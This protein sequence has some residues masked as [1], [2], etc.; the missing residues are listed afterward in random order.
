VNL[1][2]FIIAG[3]V[4]GSVY[5]LAAV[6]LVL[7]YKTSGIFNF[8]YGALATVAAYAFYSLYVQ[9]GV[10]L[11]V[12]LLISSVVLGVALGFA[13]EPFARRLGHTALALQV[14]AT[15]GIVLIVESSA[16]IIYGPDTLTFPQWLPVNTVLIF[17]AHVEIGQLIIFAVS[18]VATALLYS[19]LRLTR[20]GK[21]LRAVVDND[22]LIDLVG[23][24][25]R[26]LR[27]I[28]WIVGCFFAALSGLLLAPTLQLNPSV[29]TLLVIQAFGAAALGKFTSLPIAWVGGLAIGVGASLI[30]EFVPTT[31]AV[32]GGLAA[33]LPFIVLFGASFFFREGFSL[34]RFRTRPQGQQE[35]APVAGGRKR[36][37]PRLAII[38]VVAVFFLAIPTFAGARISSWSLAVT[39]IILFLSL[40]LLV[41]GSGLVSLCAV[42]FAAIGAAAFSQIGMHL[43]FPW[44]PTLLLA[45][46][47]A[48]PIGAIL[49]VPAMRIGG[50]F[51]ALATLG[52][53]LLVQSMFYE[54]S[55]MFGSN[56]GGI[57]VPMPSI[58]ILGISGTKAFYYVVLL[59]AVVTMLFMFWI[60]RGR[61]GH[62]MR[63]I[64][65]QPVTLVASGARVEVTHVLIFCISAY[66][67][68]V[69]G[70]LNAMT[71][72]FVNGLSFDPTMSLTLLTLVVITV[73]SE[74]WYAI[75][76]G[77]GIALIPAYVNSTDTAYYLQLIFGLSAVGMAVFHGKLR[78]PAVLTRLL[79][80]RSGSAVAVSQIEQGQGVPPLAEY[81]QPE[82]AGGE[83][84]R[85]VTLSGE[86]LRL[87]DVS[88]RFGGLVALD[89]VS[90]AVD[91]G[92]IIGLV[93]ANGAG[94]STLIN[95]CSGFVR[96]SSGHVVFGDHDVTRSDASARAR[97]GLGRTFQH[98]QLCDSLT[99]ADNV[100]IG[101]EA[102]NAGRYPWAH[103]FASPSKR[104]AEQTAT[105]D[106]LE[107]CGLVGKADVLAGHL[108][109]GERRLVEV[110]RS[111]AAGFNTLLLD[112]PFAGLGAEQVETLKAILHVLTKDRHLG[113]LL[114]EHDMSIIMS[115][116]DYIYVLDFGRLLFS[117]SPDEVKASRAVQTAYMGD[118]FQL[119]VEDG[120]EALETT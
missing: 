77:L 19:F 25:P 71:A 70:A 88:V 30:T 52:F 4:T 26:H 91:P 118:E 35:L 61:L 50:V 17:G 95:A 96:V 6:G 44:L 83:V 13:F 114:I 78:P 104:R 29:L 97:L 47:V 81:T 41:K 11:Y 59:I 51:L 54:S 99:V 92:Q 55:L 16:T 111:I 66:I 40:G 33:S 110:A 28:A 85:L 27:R 113:L 2:P 38:V 108:S 87:E 90:L 8:A 12:A 48:V 43:G 86:T 63:A 56:D 116:C 3:L 106:A 34:S 36:K 10:P 5:G 82:T 58:D 105:L 76:A 98:V 120:L 24:N 67:G 117:G 75:F 18:F 74:P 60:R 115:L 68:A 72:G 57:P 9:H 100:R 53:G 23:R 62:L 42:T 64:G 39:Y 21:A 37:G 84:V 31:T 32:L 1:A 69:A 107:L 22:E 102:R 109:T 15:V 89:K 80:R 73:G 20:L 119:M 101:P 65:E 46:C 112:E 94:K 103:A 79:A 7:T 45:G 14:A 49:A 93:G